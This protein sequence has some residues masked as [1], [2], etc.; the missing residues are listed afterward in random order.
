MRRLLV[1]FFGLF[2]LTGVLYP[3]GVAL[4]GQTLFSKKAHGSLIIEN[5]SILG[6][7]PIGQSFTKPYYFHGRPSANRYDGKRSG[8]SN[9]ALSNPRF[10]EVVKN[11][12]A[13]LK[14]EN[15]GPIPMDM[16]TTSASG[17]DPHISLD[18]A[19]FQIARV[20]KARHV[21]KN[22]VEQILNVHKEDRLLGIFGEEKVNV[23]LLNLDL[24]QQLGVSDARRNKTQP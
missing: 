15:V 8:G 14:K 6:A 23:L 19:R 9:L 16:V 1:I 3:L 20:A 11:R 24:D 17:L 12:A 22:L 13:R 7:R 21:S 5:Q 2:F 4:M 10:R 18:A